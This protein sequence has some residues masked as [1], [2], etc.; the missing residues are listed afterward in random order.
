V[1]DVAATSTE[2][3]DEQ[4]FTPIGFRWPQL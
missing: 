3:H 2:P 4:K 1:S